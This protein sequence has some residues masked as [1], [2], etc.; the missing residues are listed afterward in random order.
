MASMISNGTSN[1]AVL[2][3]QRVDET[4]A[5]FEN[6]SKVALQD[7]TNNY[8]HANPHN[9]TTV[10]DY[11]K[12]LTELRRLSTG[13]LSDP[14][15]DAWGQPI[16]GRIYTQYQ[17]LSAGSDNKNTVMVPVTAFAFVSTGPD[18]ILQT[19]IPANITN[20]SQITGIIAPSDSDDIAYTFNNLAAQQALLESIKLRLN[21]IGTATL[22]EVQADLAGYR[23]KK[24]D[25]YQTMISEGK[26]V[27]ITSVVD[28]A[29]DPDAPR[30]A[31][32]DGVTNDGR[33]H[34][35]NIGV[36]ED[37]NILERSL[38][39]GGNFI[40][41]STATTNPSDS[42]EI[43]LLN[44]KNFPTP[45]GKPASSFRYQITIQAVSSSLAN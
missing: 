35:Y 20:M 33:Q 12:G 42:F 6:I 40:V 38:S 9:A 41:S 44:S 3:K 26:D 8:Y 24:L 2:N 28:I 25:I 32:L 15:L 17:P 7:I 5:F 14:S 19:P 16:L 13:R 4:L 29:N 39:G 11:I 22:K 21:R 30:I 23:R 31:S 36:D 45:W 10:A 37:F 43:I 1:V 27:S 18:R 34:R